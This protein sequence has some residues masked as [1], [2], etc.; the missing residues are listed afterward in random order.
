MKSIGGI[1][2]LIIL[3]V[4]EAIAFA[5]TSAA[6]LVV[7]GIIVTLTAFALGIEDFKA[8]DHIE[9]VAT[10]IALV[11]I[12]FACHWRLSYNQLK[13]MSII[14]TLSI[15]QL[16]Q[17]LNDGAR[18]VVFYHT[19]SLI[20]YTVCYRSPIYYFEADEDPRKLG[21][22]SFFINTVCGWWSLHGFMWTLEHLNDSL[23]GDCVDAYVTYE[24]KYGEHP[25]MRPSEIAS[26]TKIPEYEDED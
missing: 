8:L 7:S 19:V 11:L 16:E 26:S 9:F 18:F 10:I 13:K 23:T 12:M 5:V 4:K 17:R 6:L 24:M 25:N 22:F 21:W 14:D 15:E 3:I 20:V 2:G 1:I